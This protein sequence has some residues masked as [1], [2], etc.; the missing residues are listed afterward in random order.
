MPQWTSAQVH[1]TVA[2]IVAQ[3]AYRVE[4]RSLLM[5][6]IRLV[7]E[8]VGRLLDAV[9]GSL[10]ARVVIALA[11]VAI[12]VVVA[13][14]IAIDRRAA[15]RRARR[16]G[17]TRTDGGRRD[18]WADARA[19]ADAGRY[20]DASHA[21]YV[22][23]LDALTTAGAVRYHRSKTAGDYARELRR[24]GSQL[25]SDFRAFGRGF[26]HVVFGQ[27]AASRDDYERLASLGERILAA[28][29]RAAAA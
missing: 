4:R 9:R 25:A 11:A 3:P 29:H 14:R 10:D 23:V 24:A 2:A 27:T 21:L 15:A 12:V 16:P 22:A 17:R 7:A 1:D 20:V 5:R 18:A 26:E 13:I 6:L 28:L 19:S 8:E